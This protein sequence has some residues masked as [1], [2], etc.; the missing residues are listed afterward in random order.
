MGPQAGKFFNEVHTKKGKQ[1]MEDTINLINEQWA[2][3]SN[4]MIDEG[5]KNIEDHI[6]FWRILLG[7]K[8]GPLIDSYFTKLP[9]GTVVANNG[10][11]IGQDV[12]NLLD[13]WQFLRRKVKIWPDNVKLRY[14]SSPDDCPRLWAYMKK[15]VQDMASVCDGFKLNA[16]HTPLHVSDYMIKAAREKNSNL[17]IIGKANS[18]EQIR[19]L[20][21]N[22]IVRELEDK[23]SIEELADNFR[24]ANSCGE[25][26]NL[27][28]SEFDESFHDIDGNEF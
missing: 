16:M 2:K 1:I 3:G 22:L 15:Y 28:F 21:I 20:G 11:I 8:T 13:D 17:M 5:L 25:F 18:P 23:K 10:Y 9:C 6:R 24:F 14:G 27:G 4:E 12:E 7:A 19:K 26:A